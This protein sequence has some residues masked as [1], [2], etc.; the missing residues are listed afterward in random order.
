MPFTRTSVDGKR[1]MS[2]PGSA[3]EKPFTTLDDLCSR[4]DLHAIN[5]KALE[6]LT[7]AG[8]LDVLRAA[9]GAVHP[10]P[11]FNII[12]DF[13]DSLAF[14]AISHNAPPTETLAAE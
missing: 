9:I 8:A 5:K 3:R 14:R 4:V 11:F 12:F 13:N 6:S 1:I 2:G 7:K 10:R